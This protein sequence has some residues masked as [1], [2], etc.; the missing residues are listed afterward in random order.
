MA[1]NTLL[2]T[3]P[4]SPEWLA[5]RYDPGQDAIQ[6][7]KVDR[8]F[9]RSVPF[10]IDAHLPQAREPVVLRRAD[11]VA[12][13]SPAAPTR[14][15]FH[16]AF[17]CSTLL[18]GSLDRE[19]LATSL[20]EPTILND[21]VGWRRRGAPV[22]KVAEVLDSVLR[23]LARPFNAGELVIIK[24]SNVLNSLAPGI[25]HMQPEARAL[26][27]YAPLRVFLTSVAKKGLDGRLW[28]RE[29][30]LGLRTDGLV[31][32]LGFDDQAFFGQTDLQ[33]AACGWLAQQALFADMIAAP[34]IAAQVRSLDSEE[35][36]ASPRE[37][38]LQLADHYGL[39]LEER[40]VA[41][42]LAGPFKRNSKSG[43]AFD[44]STRQEE[45]RQAIDAHSDEIDKVARW[46]E[47]VAESAGIPLKLQNALI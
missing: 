23:L 11:S 40:Q 28:V 44:A 9:R 37:A 35:L 24:P 41:E 18:A 29:L 10:L 36:L 14:F 42:L 30:F 22:P 26:L 2:A 21:V 8:D 15:V 6:F 38:L 1:A 31:Q 5:H 47:V 7:I 45:Y 43:T 17:C 4:S 13:A 39:G 46:A 34:A 19:G 33:I 32:R 20:N 16:S 12:A 3:I 25:L 27:L